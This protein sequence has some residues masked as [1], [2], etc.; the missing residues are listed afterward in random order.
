MSLQV[1]V[2]PAVEDDISVLIGF[3]R[4]LAIYEKEPDQAKAT[5]ELM[6]ENLFVKKYA[7]ALVCEDVA[8]S[9]KPIGMA[10]VRLHRLPSILYMLLIHS[11]SPLSTTSPFLRGHARWVGRS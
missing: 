9:N 1:H 7:H 8:Q 5:P 11:P 10:L 6:K 2:R 4:D 3:I